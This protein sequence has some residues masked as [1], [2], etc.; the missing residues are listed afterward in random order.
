MNKLVSVNVGKP[1]DALFN[2]RLIRTAIWK[3]PVVGRVFV[4]RTNID[5]DG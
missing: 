2:G 4:G 5:G 1:R 3:S